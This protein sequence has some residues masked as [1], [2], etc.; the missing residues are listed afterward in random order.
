MRDECNFS[1]MEG[2]KNP[3]ASRLKKQVTIRLREDCVVNGRKL[4][5]NWG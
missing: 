2:R 1:E 3:Y 4:S 5:M